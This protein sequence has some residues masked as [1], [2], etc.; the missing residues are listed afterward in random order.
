MK[1]VF[2]MIEKDGRNADINKIRI[3]NIRKLMM[4]FEQTANTMFPDNR[5]HLKEE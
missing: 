2:E 3:Q 4:C 1:F 5:F